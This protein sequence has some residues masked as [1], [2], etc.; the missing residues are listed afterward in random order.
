MFI[1]FSKESYEFGDSIP[2]EIIFVNTSDQPK[3]L[4]Q[5]PRKSID[6]QVH[7]VNS[8]TG[9]DLNYQVGKIQVTSAGE[10]FAMAVP[11]PEETVIPPKGMLSFSSDLNERLYLTPGEYRCRLTNYRVDES[12]QAR[13]AVQL[14]PAG[15]LYLLKIAID[16]RQSYGR[17]EWAQDW[18]KKMQ[19]D[20][21]LRLSQDTDTDAK[22]KADA[23]F[24]EKAYAQYRQWWEANRNSPVFLERVRSLNP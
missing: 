21:E 9:E 14:T 20:I 5:D 24:N 4:P 22:K 7:A 23:D 19:P 10:M 13:I 1:Q 11:V 15:Y 3:T 2:A 17:R 6:L 18:L 8:K 16:A 12:N